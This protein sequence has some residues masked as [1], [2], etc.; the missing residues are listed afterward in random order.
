MGA[1]MTTISPSQIKTIRMCPRKWRFAKV[2]KYPQPAFA[3]AELGTRVHALVEAEIEFY[4][5]EGRWAKEAHDAGHEFQ[6]AM[7][8]LKYLPTVHLGAEVERYI[9]PEKFIFPEG[10][11]Q[12]HG[13]IDLLEPHRITDWKTSGNLRYAPSAEEL[14]NDPQKIIYTRAATEIFGDDVKAYRHVYVQT[15]GTMKS[16]EVSLPVDRGRN[17]DQYW[18]LEGVIKNSLERRELVDPNDVPANEK[19]CSA[20]GGCPFKKYCN[21]HNEEKKMGMNSFR[22]K[23]AKLEAE[24][25]KALA[26]EAAAKG[27][28]VSESEAPAKVAAKAKSAGINIRPPGAVKTPEEIFEEST[29]KAIAEA[30]LPNPPEKTDEDIVN[31]LTG[32]AIMVSTKRDCVALLKHLG[33]EDADAKGKSLGKKQLQR[34]TLGAFIA[35]PEAAPSVPPAPAPIAPAP[36]VEAGKA[37]EAITKGEIEELVLTRGGRT[38]YINCSPSRTAVRL[39]EIIAPMCD[40]VSTEEGM[41]WG[42][43]DYGKG[44]QQVAA[45]LDAAVQGGL[46]LPYHLVIDMTHPAANHCRVVLERHYPQKVWGWK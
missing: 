15:K 11:V 3:A 12:P 23:L 17:D 27:A 16:M 32:K 28:D 7:E 9:K 31:P 22:A 19:A 42:A 36:M 30:T 34:Y 1:E 38:M 37:I 33:H 13:Y 46:E 6:L 14:A 41:Y 40:H 25:K 2:E 26:R 10:V 4:L 35:A 21:L 18:A 24:K 29:E 39:D 5:S 20:F 45:V 43:L 8:L 44:P